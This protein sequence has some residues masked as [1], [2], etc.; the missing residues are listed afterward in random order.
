[1]TRTGLAN[2]AVRRMYFAEDV[3]VIWRTKE[4][5]IQVMDITA[6]DAHRKWGGSEYE[7]GIRK[8]STAA[9]LSD[10]MC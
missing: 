9:R 7:N 10:K 3:E 6:W 8:N 1:M 5:G 2:I 4:L